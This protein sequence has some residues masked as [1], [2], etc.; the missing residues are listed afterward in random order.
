MMTALCRGAYQ[1]GGHVT[2]ILIDPKRFIPEHNFHHTTEEFEGIVLRQ[3]RLLEMGDAFVA[4]PGG[5][6]TLYEVAQ[7]VAMKSLDEIPTEK[8]MICVGNTWG[9]LKAHFQEMVDA[10]LCFRDPFDQVTF[11]ATPE[12]AIEIL[13]THRGS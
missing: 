4:L 10:G 13:K 12:E 7:V 11:V 6:G 3:A 9:N 8:P 2:G 5:V 1:A